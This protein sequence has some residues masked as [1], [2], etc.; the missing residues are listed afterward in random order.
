M[1]KRKSKIGKKV[2][3]TVLCGLLCGGLLGGAPIGY[4]YYKQYKTQR[5]MEAAEKQEANQLGQTGGNGAYVQ[6]TV[7]DRDR[8]ASVYDVS[9]VWDNVIP[10]MVEIDTKY[11]TA[12]RFFGHTYEEESEGR[13]TGIIIAQG[14]ELFLVTNHHV[15]DGATAIQIKFVDGSTAPAEL[16]GADAEADI[17][18][19]SVDFSDLQE[20]TLKQ[21]RVATIGDSGELASGEMVIA[22]GNAAGHG[23][24]LTVGYVSALDREV[25]I[26][27]VTMNLIQTDAAINPGNSGGAL[28]NAKGELVGINNAKLVASDVEG[29]GYS[30]PVSK[31]V[32]LINQL[33][34]RE[35]IRYRDSAMLGIIVQ[36]VTENLSA[37]LNIPRGVYIVEV[38]EDSAAAKAGIPL[39][40]VITEVNG[41]SVKSQEQLN[42]VLSYIRGGT[43]GTVTVQERVEGE[44]TPKEYT[45][46]FDKRGGRR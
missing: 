7:A 14:D 30:I 33:M 45:V 36:D 40:G 34:N 21:I 17:A 39:Y 13:G 1:K 9:T 26:E 11:V 28:L 16:K 4:S 41:I 38:E 20:E 10:A 3:V 2:V 18:V 8:E 5:E 42:E 23:Q 32:S 12:Y 43:T 31:V 24:S 25:T 22:I 27:G 15:V 6:Q 35:E 44:Y 46:T 37:T 19:L 29:V